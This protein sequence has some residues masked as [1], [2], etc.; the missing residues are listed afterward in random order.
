MLRHKLTGR[1]KE[2]AKETAIQL[3][4]RALRFTW[5][6]LALF[7][8]L[9]ALNRWCSQRYIRARKSSSSFKFFWKF[10]WTKLRYPRF[11]TTAFITLIIWVD[12]KASPPDVAPEET[13]GQILAAFPQPEL[14]RCHP[15]LVQ[16]G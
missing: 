9:T 16:R 3:T 4:I 12:G 2:M 11:I 5:L 15:K 7:K 13:R 1:A 14:P 10:C 6:Y 8:P